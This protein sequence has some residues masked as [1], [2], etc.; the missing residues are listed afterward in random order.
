MVYTV[1][2][3]A[4]LD[5]DIYTN[6]IVLGSLN[7]ADKI[8]YKAGGKGIMVSKV[9]K[10]LNI[11]TKALGFIGGFTGEFI[12]NELNMLGINHS[13][14]TSIGNTRINI[15]LFDV[16]NETEISGLS[17]AISESAIETLIEQIKQVTEDDYVVFSGSIGSLPSNIYKMIT[18]ELNPKTKTVLD[19]R[20]SLLLQ[21][22]SNNFLVKP[23]VFE[24]SEMMNQTLATHNEIA[25][26]CNLF[27]EK[28][29]E[30]V[31][32][33]L[34]SKGAIFINKDLKIFAYPCEGKLI[35]SIG[36]GDSVSGGFIAGIIKG[37]SPEN[38]FKLAVAAGSATAFSEDIAE[39]NLIYQ[40]YDSVM[41]SYF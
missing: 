8:R 12:E 41:I 36:A 17:P 28:G 38:A 21:N 24:L 7:H 22:I 16:Q 33:T 13:F 37:F 2:L 29:V 23:N 25:D 5:Y 10:N 15:K 34:G 20:G 26:A 40:L 39:A 19:T 30:N 31:I 32:V 6:P 27:I 4:S 3:N 35:N 14:V 9:L 18:K 1:T 11:E